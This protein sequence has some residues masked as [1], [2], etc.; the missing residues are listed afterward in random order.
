MT[1][2]AGTRRRPTALPGTVDRGAQPG[3][4]PSPRSCSGVARSPTALDASALDVEVHV[5]TSAADLS[6]IAAA[7]VRRR[8]RRDRVRRRRHG[9]A[10]RPGSRPSATACSASSPPGRA[11]TSPAN[12]GSPAATSRAAVARARTRHGRRA[13]T[14]VAPRPPTAR[15]R[16]SPRWPTPASTP[17]RTAGRTRQTWLTGTPALR[18]RGAAHAAHLP[19][20]TGSRHRRRR[21]S[22]RPTRGWSRSANTRSYA[23]GMVIAPDASIGDGLL[24]VCVVGPVSRAEFLRTFPKVFRGTH[25]Q[26]PLVTTRARHRGARSSARRRRAD[27]AR[28]A[29]ELWASGERVGPLPARITRR[30]ADALRASPSLDRERAF[31]ALLRGDRGCRSRRCTCRAS[32]SIFFASL[33]PSPHDLELEARRTCR[34][35]TRGRARRWSP[36]SVELRDPRRHRRPLSGLKKKL[37]GVDRRAS[38]SPA[39][40]ARRK[41]CATARRRHRRRTR[42]AT[43]PTTRWPA[44]PPTRRRSPHRHAAGATVIV[45]CMP[46][47]RGPGSCSRCCTCPP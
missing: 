29:P 11:T 41:P 24:D 42:R 5:T 25:V 13:S 37:P 27:A 12:S 16:G 4:G 22:S 28:S 17:R 30:Y 32:R 14:S 47:P 8:P 21:R 3:G 7:R 46:R 44:S 2:R 38:A 33:E 34:R 40:R 23:G 36:S 6:D 31:H 26:H 15:T 18:A 20:T 39:L 1:E 19:P 35:R 45:A 10:W 43:P 9:A